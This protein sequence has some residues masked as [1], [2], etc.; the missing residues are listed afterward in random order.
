MYQIFKW[1]GSSQVIRHFLKV[2]SKLNGS[3]M[4]IIYIYICFRFV[5]GYRALTYNELRITDF[6][7]EVYDSPELV[8]RCLVSLERH[9]L[10]LVATLVR[11]TH[12]ALYDYTVHVDNETH[13]LR[14]LHAIVARTV[15]HASETRRSLRHGTGC[16]TLLFRAY[17]DRSL[18]SRLYL[19]EALRTPLLLL[20]R[21]DE[22]FYD[23][24]EQR[25]LHRFTAEQYRRRFGAPGDV[26]HA[27]A[28]ARYR[29]V[30]VDK[31]VT[32]TRRFVE[33]LRAAMPA[34]P[35]SL[36]HL[37]AAI[38]DRLAADDEVEARA[39]CADLV[40]TMYVFPAICDPGTHHILADVPISYTA[41][42]NLMQVPRNL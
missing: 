36:R 21:E 37:I 9:A 29:A 23:V 19:T 34:F 31:L 28:V 11:I 18:A 22:W 4:V 27:A 1:I 12:D 15:R 16:L 3:A 20:V 8:A 5:D 41:N 13:V 40:F 24:D 7:R 6:V 42:H 14:A 17:T 25:A 39:A 10:H 35:Q 32:F 38:Y 30:V 26:G 2:E 33:S